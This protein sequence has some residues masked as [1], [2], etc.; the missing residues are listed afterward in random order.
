[1]NREQAL[2]FFWTVFFCIVVVCVVAVLMSY[3]AKAAENL[4]YSNW[5]SWTWEPITG[6]GLMDFVVQPLNFSTST[7]QITRIEIYVKNWDDSSTVL[8]GRI[9]S[10]LVGTSTTLTTE[11]YYSIA[12][13]LDGTTE[14]VSD[15][16][17]VSG[18]EVLPAYFVGT[19]SL[20]IWMAPEEGVEYYLVVD[21]VDKSFTAGEVVYLKRQS[22]SGMSDPDWLHYTSI[23]TDEIT[24]GEPYSFMIYFDYVAPNIRALAAS[25]YADVMMNIYNDNEIWRGEITTEEWLRN[26]NYCNVYPVTQTC[27]FGLSCAV[28]FRYSDKCLNSYAGV[29]YDT[30]RYMD[31]EPT[32]QDLD[33]ALYAASL[34]CASKSSYYMTDGNPDGCYFQIHLNP[35]SDPNGTEVDPMY[36]CVLVGMTPDGDAEGGMFCGT[37]INWDAPG[38]RQNRINE[39]HA[40]LSPDLCEQTLASCGL[41]DVECGLKK[42]AQWAFCPATST[43][44]LLNDA[45]QDS[46]QNFPINIFVFLKDELLLLDATTSSASIPLLR[47]GK[48]GERLPDEYLITPERWADP[49]FADLKYWSDKILKY[50]IYMMVLWYFVRKILIYIH[51]ADA[52]IILSQGSYKNKLNKKT[53][54]PVEYD[55]AHESYDHSLPVHVKHK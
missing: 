12:D 5:T 20:N 29:V 28:D 6:N 3:P 48:N 19:T 27:E 32:S 46:K 50:L 39:M 35:S 47:F 1:M 40:L 55:A 15:N 2:S 54:I 8:Y 33:D 30:G 14:I 38:T 24:V 10:G 37:K 52:D 36:F 43:T 44:V 23:I 13:C 9:C 18:N 21:P 53:K 41:T 34:D 26:M 31:A 7:S 45:L 25:D 11:M 51:D 16:F 22:K 4:E 49:R 42:A 17:T